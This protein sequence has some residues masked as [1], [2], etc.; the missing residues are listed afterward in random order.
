MEIEIY[1]PTNGQPLPAVKWNYPEVKAWRSAAPNVG[2][3]METSQAVA[4][5]RRR[6]KRRNVP[7]REAGNQP[8]RAQ[9]RTSGEAH[10]RPLHPSQEDR[11]NHIAQK[12]DGWGLLQMESIP[13]LPP[14]DKPKNR[15]WPPA[16]S[17]KDRRR[18]ECAGVIS[19][20][21][22]GSRQELRFKGM[23]HQALHGQGQES[24]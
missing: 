22:G 1:S 13:H 16:V 17:R 20:G 24:V 6:R 4:D 23:C 15:R 9:A 14:G 18:W 10:G 2:R 12:W 19:L 5:E 8:G 11:R 3:G 21:T 7:V